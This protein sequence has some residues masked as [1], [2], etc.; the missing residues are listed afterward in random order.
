MT[1]YLFFFFFC[2]ILNESLFLFF[3]WYE[4][5]SSVKIKKDSKYFVND[6]FVHCYSN[7]TNAKIT[8]I[9]ALVP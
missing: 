6:T 9:L 7:L 3:S 4:Y 1:G 8:P 5:E 2:L